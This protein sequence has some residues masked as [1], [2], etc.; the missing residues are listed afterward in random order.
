MLAK[1]VS[2]SADEAGGVEQVACIQA[3]IRPGC[4]VRLISASALDMVYVFKLKMSSTSTAVAISGGSWSA[5][6][7]SPEVSS[8]CTATAVPQAGR[9]K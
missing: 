3:P 9:R 6:N 2:Q 4:R 5:C 7:V 8:S 1:V